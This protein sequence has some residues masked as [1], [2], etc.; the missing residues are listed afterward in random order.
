MAKKVEIRLTDNPSNNDYVAFFPVVPSEFYSSL[1][2]FTYRT[3]PASGFITIGATKLD[4]ITNLFN[5]ATTYYS[6]YTWISVTQVTNGIDI[7]LNATDVSFTTIGAPIVG[8]LTLSFID[9]SIQPF[10]RDN[11]ILSRSPFNI[12]I[13]PTMYFDLATL[14]MKVYRGTATTD[15]PS[16]TTFPLSKAVIQAGQTRINFE[17]AKFVNDYCKSNIPTFGTTGVYTSTSYDSVW[18]DAEIN[19]YYLGTL[20]GTSNKQYYAIDGFGYHI[21]LYNPKLTKNVLSTNTTH[22]VYSGSDYPLYF[23]SK[24]LVSITID[25]NSVSFTLDETINN[26]LVAYV[27]IGSYI[28][29]QSSFTAVFNYGTT[30]E[31]HTFIVK[32]ACKY[33]LYNVFFKNRFGFWQSIPFNLRSK[34]T[35]NVESSDYMPVVSTYGAYSLQ[36]HNKKSYQPS[37]KEVITLNTDFIPEYYNNIIKEMM[38]SEFIYVENNGVYLPVNLNKKSIDVKK[39]VFDKLIQYT[40]D[41][42]YSFNLMN[43]VI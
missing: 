25:G 40:F 15:A 16:T 7:L 36:S 43:S 10:T 41:F 4:S 17:V 23:V 34:S 20:I 22:I 13:Q 32:E 26:Q 37:A 19:A 11:I 33:P 5:F 31:T 9:V 3:T 1:T 2:T 42:E 35:I 12:D 30:T 29:T 24:D 27:N 6:S 39:K 38:L 18:L 14:N 21:E 28:T 8:D